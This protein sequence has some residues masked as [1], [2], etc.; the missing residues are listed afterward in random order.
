MSRLLTFPFHSIWTASNQLT[1]SI[2]IELRALTLLTG[3]SLGT[4]IGLS[5]SYECH[6]CSHL[7]AIMFEQIK[8]FWLVT[9]IRSFV[10]DHWIFGF[11]I[12]IALL[13]L[14]AAAALNVFNAD[15]VTYSVINED[16]RQPSHYITNSNWLS[17]FLV[18]ILLLLPVRFRANTSTKNSVLSFP[19]FSSLSSFWNTSRQWQRDLIRSWPKRSKRY[20]YY[21]VSVGTMNPICLWVV[22]LSTGVFLQIAFRLCI[23]QCCYLIVIS[24]SFRKGMQ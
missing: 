6:A 11:F 2:P 23:K 15:K 3:L 22:L 17:H 5:C 12:L 10:M 13:K 16:Y 14:C 21:G 8:M 4:W 19:L 18:N 20:R 1:G 9:S 24:G 7:L